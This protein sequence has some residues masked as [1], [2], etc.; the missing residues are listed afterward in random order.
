MSLLTL[1]LIIIVVGVL[2]W[3]AVRFI[4]MEPNVKNILVAVVVIVLVLFILRAFGLL[5][6]IDRIRIR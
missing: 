6:T 5:D 1:C 2:L 3:L 4:P